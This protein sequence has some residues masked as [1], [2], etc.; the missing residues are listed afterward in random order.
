MIK[1]LLIAGLLVHGA[2]V[3]GMTMK[4]RVEADYF[5]SANVRDCTAGMSK[6]QKSYFENKV[7]DLMY[8]IRKNNEEGKRR[9]TSPFKNFLFEAVEREGRLAREKQEALELEKRRLSVEKRMKE[10]RREYK[11]KHQGIHNIE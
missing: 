1:Q 4:A 3:Y 6:E 11:Q 5:H 8:S 9:E 10:A 7:I 2:S